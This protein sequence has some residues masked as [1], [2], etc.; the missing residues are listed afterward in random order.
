ML[1]TIWLLVSYMTCINECSTI[2]RKCGEIQTYNIGIRESTIYIPSFVC[3][4]ESYLNFFSIDSNPTDKTHQL[5]P[6]PII[7]ALHGFHNDIYKFL[8]EYSRLSVFAE[9]YGFIVIAPIGLYKS[10]NGIYCCGDAVIKNINDLQFIKNTISTSIT[11]ISILFNDIMTIDTNNIQLF[12]TGQSNGG[13]MTDEIAWAYA[14]GEEFLPITAFAPYLGYMYD[15]NDVKLHMSIT[16]N[17]IHKSMPIFFQLGDKDPYVRVTGCCHKQKCAGKLRIDTFKENCTSL[18]DEYKKWLN[19][20][21][22]HENV[23][24]ESIAQISQRQFDTQRQVKCAT[25]TVDEHGC[26]EITKMCIFLGNKHD[27]HIGKNVDDF[28]TNLLLFF[29]EIMCLKYG[30]IW[31]NN[32][33]NTAYCLCYNGLQESLFCMDVTMYMSEYESIRIVT[34]NPSVSP[35]I[36]DIIVSESLQIVDTKKMEVIEQVNNNNFDIE[37]E[38]NVENGMEDEE[39]HDMDLMF[40]FWVTVGCVGGIIVKQC[41][42]EIYKRCRKPQYESFE[43]NENLWL[44]TVE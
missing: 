42:T 27:A 40:M 41:L 11:N 14:L 43:P 5:L 32:A 4:K 3:N 23:T 34:G 38:G 37:F 2:E 35:T 7:I 29:Y 18:Y 39:E 1:T 9:Q 33:N 30:G 22:C 8:Q 26:D 12:I 21:H 24:F 6:I 13:F 44:K 16:D 17:Y 19:W 31:D 10:W 25:A 28:H 20:N 36:T 15:V